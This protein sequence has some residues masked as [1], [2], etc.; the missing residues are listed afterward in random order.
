MIGVAPQYSTQTR[1]VAMVTGASNG[2]GQEFA[3]HLAGIGHD[4]VLADIADCA[5]TL[6]RCEAAGARVVAATCDVTDPSSVGEMA[7]VAIERL[8]TIDILVHC[9]GIYPIQ[10]F[11][12]ISWEDWRRVLSVNLD[13]MFHLAKSVLPG[14][15]ERGWGRI[16]AMASTTF[17][18]GPAGFSHYT[19]SKG[20]VIGFVRSLASE[21]GD[22]G[23]TVNAIAPGL[24][25]N[26]TTEAGPQAGFF[27]MVAAGQ[28]IK[29]TAVPA[30]L[31]GALTFLTSD[32]AAFVTGQTMVVDGGGVRS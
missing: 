24:V 22:D 29:R 15:R 23:V 10:T 9:A 4:I 6:G 13:S 30:D 12:Q 25:R 17:H 18:A 16:V 26:A 2:I 3:A 7:A 5:T 21:C 31:L 20:G 28:A 32:A 11:D 14:M 1:R 19:A 8:G 27:D